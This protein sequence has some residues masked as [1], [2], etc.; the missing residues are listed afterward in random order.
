MH[1]VGI[2]HEPDVQSLET[3]WKVIWNSAAMAEELPVKYQLLECLVD[4]LEVLARMLG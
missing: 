1:A 3:C 4:G 2:F